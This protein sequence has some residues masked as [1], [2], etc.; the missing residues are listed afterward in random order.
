ME[1]S[2][3]FNLEMG[4]GRFERRSLPCD[5]T[6][7][8]STPGNRHIKKL[9]SSTILSLEPSLAIYREGARTH[10]HAPIR[11]ISHEAPAKRTV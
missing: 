2:P 5:R 11:G 10:A 6:V 3:C 1:V 7:P 4:S 8:W 9:G